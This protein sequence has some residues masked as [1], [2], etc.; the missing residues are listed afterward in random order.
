MD[1]FKKLNFKDK[2]NLIILAAF[3][4]AFLAAIL[5]G[6]LAFHQPL[7]AVV[8]IMLLDIAIAVCLHNAELWLHGT[9]MIVV[10]IVGILV[11]RIS[12]AVIAVIMYA[13]TICALKY[14]F[15]NEN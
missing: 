8:C 15:A 9:L 13:V 10:L 1:M 6:A 7:V 14:L 3:A 12:M 2:Q 4:V 11:P 5:V